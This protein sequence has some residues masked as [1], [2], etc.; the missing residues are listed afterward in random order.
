MARMV[1]AAAWSQQDWKFMHRAASLLPRE[2]QDGAFYRA[3]LCVHDENWTEA[4]DLIDAARDMLDTEV[5]ALSLE[6]YQRGESTRWSLFLGFRMRHPCWNA[7]LH[8]PYFVVFCSHLAWFQFLRKFDITESPKN[9]KAVIK[10]LFGRFLT[11]IRWFPK[12]SIPSKRLK[13][14]ARQSQLGRHKMGWF[15]A[16]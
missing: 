7:Q 15:L 5:T 16:D 13:K 6:S 10:Q 14:G 11:V 2:S 8:K 1:S 4:Q 12:L 9:C 3:V